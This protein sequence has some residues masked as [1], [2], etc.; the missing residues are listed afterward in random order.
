MTFRSLGIF[1]FLV[2]FHESASAFLTEKAFNVKRPDNRDPATKACDTIRTKNIQCKTDSALKPL[3]S[4]VE[5]LEATCKDTYKKNNC[6][7]LKD[8][9]NFKDKLLNCGPQDLCQSTVRVAA[10]C[11]WNDMD[12][13]STFQQSVIDAVIGTPKM[14]FDVMTKGLAENSACYDNKNGEK[15]LMIFLYEKQV[16][17]ALAD[18]W[19]IPAKSRE[20]YL[21]MDCNRLAKS[22]ADRLR[23]HNRELIEK[24]QNGEIARDTQETQKVDFQK[25]TQEQV[26]AFKKLQAMMAEINTKA[27][28]MTPQARGEVLCK[29]AILAIDM[30]SAI[31]AGVLVSAAT[32]SL[33]GAAVEAK[34][35]SDGAA[36]FFALLLGTK[37][38]VNKVEVLPPVPNA[39][40]RDVAALPAPDKTIDLGRDQYVVEDISP[41]KGR[42][43]TPERQ[44]SATARPGVSQRR[45]STGRQSAPVRVR[46]PRPSDD[47]LK[48]RS[49]LSEAD[50]GKEANSLLTKWLGK[51]K[52]L[53]PDQVKGL[54][55][56]H[57]MF[58]GKYMR[59][60]GVP[61]DP[62]IHY[63]PAELLAKKKELISKYKFTEQQADVLIREGLAGSWLDGLLFKGKP[64]V[65]AEKPPV[66]EKPAPAREVASPPVASS[67]TE[68]LPTQLFNE[69]QVGEPLYIPAVHQSLVGQTVAI[70]RN[71]GGYSIG[72]IKTVFGSQADVVMEGGAHKT[73]GFK[74]LRTPGDAYVSP[75]RAARYT[76]NLNEVAPFGEYIGMENG[77]NASV[78]R[79]YLGASPKRIP[80]QG[81]KLH[82]SASV[83]N[84]DDIAKRV[85]P[86]LRERGVSHKVATDL[87]FYAS[88]LNK[89]GNT[90]AGKFIVVYPKDE[91]EAVE[92]QKAIAE[93]L[94]GVDP[95]TLPVVKDEV[96]PSPGVFAR[97]GINRGRTD[98]QYV[99]ANGVPT[100]IKENRQEAYPRNLVRNP[101]D[102][103][104]Q[105]KPAFIASAPKPSTAPSVG[106]SLKMDNGFVTPG[107]I[108]D[109]KTVTNANV[110]DVPAGSAVS[111]LEND[112]K[113]GLVAKDGTKVNGKVFRV[114]DN[115]NVV[116]VQVEGSTDLVVV[117]R[118][119]VG[120]PNVIPKPEPA[121][122]PVLIPVGSEV[123]APPPP[124]PAAVAPTSVRTEVPRDAFQP[125]RGPSNLG[126]FCEFHNAKV[127]SVT[128]G[129]PAPMIER[130]MPVGIT[131]QNGD[132]LNGKILGATDGKSVVSVELETGERMVVG[133][134]Q[135]GRSFDRPPGFQPPTFVRRGPSE[136]IGPEN[137]NDFESVR[138]R[139]FGEKPNPA[140]GKIK[141]N[142]EVTLVSRYDD[143]GIP[144]KVVGVSNNGNV[145]AVEF[146]NG[147]KVLV[148][149]NQ[150]ESVATQTPAK[151]LGQ[152][153][154]PSAPGTSL[155]VPPP[156]KPAPAG[157][158]ESPA[159][160]GSSTIN[161]AAQARSPSLTPNRPPTKPA[162]PTLQQREVQALTKLKNNA[163]DLIAVRAEQR[164]LNTD[165][166]EI[167]KIKL[168]G[169]SVFQK[170][171][172][173]N[174]NPDRVKA[175]LEKYGLMGKYAD[176]FK[177]FNGRLRYQ[178]WIDIRDDLQKKAAELADQEASLTTSF[179]RQ[180]QSG[181]GET[182]AGRILHGDG[183]PRRAQTPEQ[184]LDRL[185]TRLDIANNTP[186]T[187]NR[188]LISGG[189]RPI[190]ARTNPPAR[191]PS[192]YGR[193][194][195]GGPRGP[196]RRATPQEENFAHSFDQAVKK[197]AGNRDLDSL[198]VN[199]KAELIKE[200]NNIMKSQGIKSR[201]AFLRQGDKIDTGVAN[202]GSS[203][204]I[205]L[206]KQNWKKFTKMD[207]DSNHVVTSYSNA[208][209]I[210]ER[211]SRTVTAAL[212][213]GNPPNPGRALKGFTAHLPAKT[214]NGSAYGQT[215]LESHQDILTVAPRNPEKLRQRFKS[216]F[217]Q[218]IQG[219]ASDERLDTA[220]R[221]FNVDPDA[222]AE[223]LVTLEKADPE[224]A[225]ILRQD[226]DGLYR[227]AVSV[228]DTMDPE[229]RIKALANPNNIRMTE[230]GAPVSDVDAA[231]LLYQRI[232][233]AGKDKN[234]SV[235]D[236]RTR[237]AFPS[238]ADAEKRE[239]EAREA[240]EK[241]RELKEQ[242]R[243][244]GLSRSRVREQRPYRAN[245]P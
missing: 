147:E 196:V 209:R 183:M 157:L 223:K 90:Q 174:Y 130:D 102:P 208:D 60:D 70:P 177:E 33:L 45:P 221:L 184:V 14:L 213:K 84:A 103:A 68:A 133:R 58:P 112:M 99:D 219:G 34:V 200:V 181:R 141:M 127:I 241:D 118:N 61:F 57:E 173:A 51:Q 55:K 42:G 77:G 2:I 91:K 53:T 104:S 228:W 218:N 189:G 227:A 220:M 120:K 86:I 199:E 21:E 176:K 126:D 109:F 128:P 105:G 108:N 5:G 238:T 72:R 217:R 100:G 232:L 229:L 101:F 194:P 40:P 137:L 119:Q 18:R 132:K 17:P 192:Q 179:N 172:L 75:E 56:V 237:S 29:G 97:Y 82:V 143:E 206:L 178:T 41:P 146:A 9:S 116:V 190:P 95:K 94:K 230:K 210:G 134:D 235:L 188:Q 153:A 201:E 233:A 106:H 115:G 168:D 215:I 122:A 231:K 195:T 170:Q 154:S 96:N 3:L 83:D 186:A 26:E 236:P 63:N 1:L 23:E 167:G 214:A 10:K 135:V 185:N 113:V 37:V 114:S 110:R 74:L 25:L 171:D 240:A 239:R 180:I 19:N 125:S 30:A 224:A 166:N 117:G 64:A 151:P 203:P 52:P 73:V 225:K 7:S 65:V 138:N 59:P 165:L 234:P 243:R 245:A 131:M 121:A 129:Q 66:V 111:S 76:S 69:S 85:L 43:E 161:P 216:N 87:K 38:K 22:L 191:K 142:S 35:I 54:Q 49:L 149:R 212:Y 27:M 44:P 78:W 124:A 98:G 46:V 158:S 8:D 88:E 145:I 62:K 67:P 222:A 50:R 197:I 6:A 148:G 162:R 80:N 140:V 160:L 207:I 159:T 24:V 187:T 156:T 226:L 89:P 152:L 150:I 31:A 39:P 144:A 164:A 244:Q 139:G 13:A 202:D 169:L 20:N 28:C 12:L 71:G 182:P 4:V 242:E 155:G 48:A 175:S 136:A 47:V 204:S 16:H 193:N 198:S 211:A 81:W 205:A 36:E 79:D 32:G 15:D 93:A 163:D 92:I 107:T 11:V 123:R